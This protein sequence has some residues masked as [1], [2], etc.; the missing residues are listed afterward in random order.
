MNK[1]ILKQ[2][3]IYAES[4]LDA[5]KRLFSSPRPTDR[6]YLLALWHCQQAI[7]K[8]LKMVIMKKGKEL[9]KIHDLPRLSELAEIELPAND[10]ELVKKLNKYYL[11]SRYP[12]IMYK[13]LPKPNKNITKEYLERTK[14][15][16]LWLKKQ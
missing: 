16:F 15:L 2:W 9:L 10:I 5:A 6:T 7:E 3:I 8:A 14:K 11:K 1:E 4:D 13:P 12:D